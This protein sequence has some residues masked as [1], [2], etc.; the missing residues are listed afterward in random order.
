LA[1]SAA[2]ARF[3]TRAGLF[4]LALFAEISSTATGVLVRSEHAITV[5]HFSFSCLSRTH[6]THAPSESLMQ[7]ILSPF[8]V[9]FFGLV[10]ATEPAT[11]R[12]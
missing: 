12:S 5:I 11:A 9:N 8:K 6:V 10:N 2:T 4:T 7:T 1:I 3:N